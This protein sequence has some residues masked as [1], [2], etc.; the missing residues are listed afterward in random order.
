[1]ESLLRHGDTISGGNS[2]FSGSDIPPGNYSIET[3]GEDSE[4]YYRAAPPCS[5]SRKYI[6]IG[7]NGDINHLSGSM[8]VAAGGSHTLTMTLA[9][10]KPLIIGNTIQDNFT[11]VKLTT[12]SN[13][14]FLPRSANIRIYVETFGIQRDFGTTH[15]DFQYDDSDNP[16]EPNVL[17]CCNI[18]TERALE[19]LN[20]E[21]LSPS[22]PYTIDGAGIYVATWPY[23]DIEI[24]T[25][26]DFIYNT[27]RFHEV[28]DKAYPSW[29]TFGVTRT[30]ALNIWNKMID[31]EWE[32]HETEV[33]TVPLDYW[34]VQFEGAIIASACPDSEDDETASFLDPDDIGSDGSGGSGEE[35]EDLSDLDAIRV[36]HVLGEKFAYKRGRVIAVD[37]GKNQG[38]EESVI[39]YIDVKVIFGKKS[40][41]LQFLLKSSSSTCPDHPWLYM[42][43]LDLNY[44]LKDESESTVI[45]LCT[46]GQGKNR[47]LT[48]VDVIDLKG[49]N[50]KI[51]IDA[52]FAEFGKIAIISKSLNNI[53]IDSAV[54]QSLSE[55]DFYKYK[56]YNSN[57]FGDMSISG[58]T[59]S[60]N[61]IKLVC[62][63]WADS[64]IKLNT[65]K[66]VESSSFW[67]F[68]PYAEQQLTDSTRP[69]AFRLAYGVPVVDSKGRIFVFYPDARR[70]I[71]AAM[72]VDS[73]YTWFLFDGLI[74]LLQRESARSPFVVYN[75]EKDMVSLFYLYESYSSSGD[76]LAVKHI[77]MSLF[78][79]SE[80]FI[81][82]EPPENI[83]GLDNALSNFSKSG[84]AL[85][86]IPSIIIEG[87]VPDEV[88]EESVSYCSDA[89]NLRDAVGGWGWAKSGYAGLNRG[90]SYYEDEMKKGTAVLPEDIGTTET[91][92]ARF[93][94]GNRDLS[95]DLRNVRFAAYYDLKGVLRLVGVNDTFSS[96]L[97]SSKQTVIQRADSTMF[98]SSSHDYYNW[99]TD[100]SDI[101]FHKKQDETSVGDE[102]YTER[103]YSGDVFRRWF[104]MNAFLCFSASKW[105]SVVNCV[106]V[107]SSVSAFSNTG[108]CEESSQGKVNTVIPDAED[109]K[110]LCFRENETQIDLGPIEVISNELTGDVVVVFSYQGDMFVRRI[111]DRMID[112]YT[113]ENRGSL[114]EK[115]KLAIGNTFNLTK[116]SPN[117]PVFIAGSTP[118][119]SIDDDYYDTSQRVED[120]DAGDG[121]LSG[122]KP[123][124]Y[125]TRK[126]LLRVLYFDSQADIWGISLSL[127]EFSVV[128]EDEVLEVEDDRDFG[129]EI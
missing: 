15:D 24:I 124:A 21:V 30:E 105:T 74:K 101:N 52:G 44:T 57:A 14:I 109:L 55:D 121:V 10:V 63:K 29:K 58:N 104:L 100:M 70:N 117:K 111:V 32:D 20:V 18:D 13:T 66:N 12:V 3:T 68:A 82:Y 27:V 112:F 49:H 50:G 87:N 69:T 114:T 11:G 34:T 36:D 2:F 60:I 38:K 128:I 6:S 97:E 17:E 120:N 9:G 26:T 41:M 65:E 126:G 83:S 119:S 42:R 4:L 99:V 8:Y 73:G 35:D 110:K 25:S 47:I 95:L 108:C 53:Q 61:D 28:K 51:R 43:Y 125:F 64:S 76:L 7:D 123:G 129:R 84:I 56:V 22:P 106:G 94:L 46:L 78:N 19:N 88:D 103:D 96:G 91:G 48:I 31:D 79:A 116:T 122:I 39:P 115:Q 23:S 81:P 5:G 118:I 92:T 37:G 72:S 80:A 75:R 93:L 90:W 77:P 16:G 62:N 113:E 102:T 71:S 98:I 89:F 54:A 40:G 59:I 67:P 127:P 107:P 86:N 1:L 33:E 45:T 85:R